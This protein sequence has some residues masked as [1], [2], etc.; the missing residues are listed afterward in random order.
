MQQ[1]HQQNAQKCK[2]C[3]T[4]LT[5]KRTLICSLRAETRRQSITWSTSFRKSTLG[6]SKFSP[7]LCHDYKARVD[8]VVTNNFSE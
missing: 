2:E 1:N 4:K 8:F 5:V 6:E 3:G 7:A